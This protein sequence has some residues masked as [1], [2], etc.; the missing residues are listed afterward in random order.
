MNILVYLAKLFNRGG[1]TEEINWHGP[2]YVWPC[3]QCHN[4]GCSSWS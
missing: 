4:L 2:C 3:L 1:W